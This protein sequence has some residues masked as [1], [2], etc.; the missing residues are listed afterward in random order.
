[1]AGGNKKIHEHPN[2]NSNGF[3]KRPQDATRG[4][5]KPS[6]RTQLEAALE[7]DGG[8]I[9]IPTKQITKRHEDGS[10]TIQLPTSEQMA[11]RLIYWA[12]S[13]KGTDSLKAIQMIMDQIDGKPTQTVEQ[14]T[15]KEKVLK[16]EIIDPVEGTV[17][18][19]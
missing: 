2:A 7:N 1:M 8:G 10:V 15:V 11:L 9:T 17:T 14:T 4:G 16:I 13:K 18:E 6:I 12:M 5:R 3:D 19:M